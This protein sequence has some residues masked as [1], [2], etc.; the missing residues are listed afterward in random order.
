MQWTIDVTYVLD[1]KTWNEHLH[2]LID[3]IRNTKNEKKGIGRGR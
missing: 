1:Q 2:A 3:V